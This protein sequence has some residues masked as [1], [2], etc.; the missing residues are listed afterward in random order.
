MKIADNEEIQL[1][2]EEINALSPE[3][4]EEEY[5]SLEKRQPD[6]FQFLHEEPC[7]YTNANTGVD[8][9]MTT[10]AGIFISR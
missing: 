9:M 6:I 4:R 3:E 7:A 2:W 10:R 1:I 5:A 8:K